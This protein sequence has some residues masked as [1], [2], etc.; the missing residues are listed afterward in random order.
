MIYGKQMFRIF[1]NQSNGV[2]KKI[3]KGTFAVFKHI[4]VVGW[5]LVAV[6]EV[7]ISRTFGP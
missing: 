3:R 2:S 7:V 5:C 6:K 1:I 4:N